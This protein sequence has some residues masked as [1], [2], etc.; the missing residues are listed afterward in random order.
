MFTPLKFI[1]P[2]KINK[3]GIKKQIVVI[4]ICKKAEN[5][6][7]EKLESNF[8]IKVQQYKNN[9]LFIKTGNFQIANE[10][11][12]LEYDLKK[13]L[14]KNNISVLNIRYLI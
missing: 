9:T 14:K 2:E 3:L 10:I 7:N 8:K 1:L 12:F 6:I 11:K 5:I 4:D 13:E